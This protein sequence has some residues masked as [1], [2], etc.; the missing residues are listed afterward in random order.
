MRLAASLLSWHGFL[1][2]KARGAKLA[3]LLPCWETLP[4]WL[5]LPFWCA[6]PPCCTWLLNLEHVVGH[7]CCCLMKQ[8]PL[9]VYMNSLGI[10]VCL[11]DK[12]LQPD[13][14]SSAAHFVTIAGWLLSVLPLQKLFD[15]GH[16]MVDDAEDD[17]AESMPTSSAQESGNQALV[18]HLHISLVMMDWHCKY[19][20]IYLF[21]VVCAEGYSCSCKGI[22]YVRGD[23]RQAASEC[24]TTARLLVSSTS[25]VLGRGSCPEAAH[26]HPFAC[27]TSNSGSGVL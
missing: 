23:C 9:W 24:P 11:Q 12:E 20:R 14:A 4:K 13:M 25:A 21:W 8:R 3:Q 27:Y 19:V 5:A 16:A 15:T 10:C 7:V 2:K 26:I 22:T 6:F 17:D 18:L 1:Q